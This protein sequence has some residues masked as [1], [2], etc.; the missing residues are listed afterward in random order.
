MEL[1]T[2]SATD[3]ENTRSKIFL[4]RVPVGTVPLLAKNDK[5]DFDITQDA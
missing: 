1:S 4:K 5:H 2:P 3:V